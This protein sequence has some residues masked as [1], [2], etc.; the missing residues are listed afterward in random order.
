MQRMI[1]S[2]FALVVLG[3]A[4]VAFLVSG[5]PAVSK[6]SFTREANTDRSGNDMKVVALAAEQD[7]TACEAMC[8]AT[9]GCVAY[10]YVK[11]SKTVPLPVCRIKDAQPFGHQSSCCTSGALKK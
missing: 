1:F 3:A 6:A 10:T 2:V 11:Q 4:P 5:S 7:E 9:K 8:A